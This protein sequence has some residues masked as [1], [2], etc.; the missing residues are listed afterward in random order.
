MRL[1]RGIEYDEGEYIYYTEAVWTAGPQRVRRN[2]WQY[3]VGMVLD[4]E[5][6]DIDRIQWNKNVTE[7]RS[8][9]GT[10]LDGWPRSENDEFS[11]YESV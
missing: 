7:I 8:A 6:D 5:E 11:E 2:M 1:I 10:L 4:L 3:I 9:D